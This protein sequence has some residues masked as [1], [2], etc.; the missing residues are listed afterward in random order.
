MEQEEVGRGI[1]VLLTGPVY[2]VILMKKMK[3]LNNLRYSLTS[4]QLLYPSLLTR[5]SEFMY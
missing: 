1:G 4:D 3:G 2:C 5:R